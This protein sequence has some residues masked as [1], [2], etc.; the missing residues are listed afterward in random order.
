MDGWTELA[1]AITATG[2]VL[3]L[4]EHA[5]HVEIRCNGWEL[6]SNRAHHSETQMAVLTCS[7][8]ACARP[9]GAAP[10]VLIGGLGMGYTLRAMLNELPAEARII[11]AELLPE[12]I[13][14][15][16]GVLGR[17]AAHPLRDARVSVTCADIADLLSRAVEGGLDAIVLDVDNGPDAVMLRG[18]ASLYAAEGLR[19]M[20]RA[21]TGSGVLAVWSAD[22]S[23]RFEQALGDAGLQWQSI[24]VPARGGPDDPMHTI[25]LAQG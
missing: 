19:R 17:L 11:V 3:V 8:L 23:P 21:L 20:R 1:R 7:R 25:Y 16:R 13:D 14:W 24:Q 10:R 15:N 2:D 5:G 6:M 18:N 9:T 12:V 4:R 22:P